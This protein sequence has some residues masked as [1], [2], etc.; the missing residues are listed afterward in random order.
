MDQPQPAKKAPMP[1]AAYTNFLRIAQQGSEF[2]LAFGQ[3]MHGEKGE[4]TGAQLVSSLV[5]TPVHLK[6][7]A[8]ALSQAVEAHE[9]R[10]G[11]I[12][13]PE[14]GAG[15]AARGDGSPAKAGSYTSG[16]QRSAPESSP[17]RAQKG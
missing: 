13:V 1:P 8:T 3:L 7:M 5:T 12:A 17:K 16:R 14:S 9:K 11:K 4:P 6:A 10:F 2:F 15:K